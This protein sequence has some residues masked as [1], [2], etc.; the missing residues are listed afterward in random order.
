MAF[1]LSYF[2]AERAR[3]VSTA[4]LLDATIARAE[5][6]QALNAMISERFV[7]AKSELAALAAPDAHALS[8]IPMVH[9]DLF[10]TAGTRTTCGSKML[11]NFV[12]P[13]SAT[14]VEKLDAVGAIC[15]G[16]ASMDE[17]AMGSSNEH[18]YFGAVS[19][20]WD[21]SRVPG[22][23]S[24]GSAALVAARVVPYATASDTGGSIRQPAAFCGVTGFKPS[25]GRV[26]RYGMVAYA[27][28]LDQAGVIAQSAADCATVLQVMAGFDVRDGT[29]LDVAVP[30]YRA[31]LNTSVHGLKIGVPRAIFDG[32]QVGLDPVLLSTVQ[33]ALRTLEA[34]GAR[35]VQVDLAHL[36]AALAA[37]YVIAPCEASSNLA[38]FDGVRY[39]HRCENPK[40]LADLYARSRAE[41]FGAEVRKRILL[42]TYALSAGYF[43]AYY[44]RAQRVR[45][46]VSE[47][48]QA[49]FAQV[50]LIAMPTTP[51][52]AFK[53]GDAG[54]NPMAEVLADIFTVGVNLAGLPAISIPAGF[55]SNLPVG[56][57][58][59]APHLREEALFSAAHQFQSHSDFHRQAPPLTRPNSAGAST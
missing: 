52:V 26:S 20:P 9:K 37:Y 18:S 49:A 55:V 14:I 30:D 39:G 22:G 42:G 25:Y 47:S 50:D 59:I 6:A 35:L 11:A 13:Y 57:Q 45:R 56:L 16:K 29:S 31:A 21:L 53:K 32:S 28:S 40:S 27:S 33:A 46:L 36:D 38:R 7:Q 41:G 43:D 23:S 10:C 58:L 1:D 8:G 24:G 34:L 17:F 19:N 3:G 48:Y 4:A 15:V 5:S 12:P 54:A 51:T 44:L 2:H